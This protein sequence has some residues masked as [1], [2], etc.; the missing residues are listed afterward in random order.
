M[1]ELAARER[2]FHAQ[3]IGL[4]LTA[5]A[6]RMTEVAGSTMLATGRLDS[7]DSAAYLQPFLADIRQVNGIPV[8]VLFTDYPLTRADD[9]SLTW[10]V[11][12]VLQSGTVPAWT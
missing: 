5:L 9:G 3:T 6:T 2:Q 1:N 12:A 11:P 8:E 10:K 7:V 4:N